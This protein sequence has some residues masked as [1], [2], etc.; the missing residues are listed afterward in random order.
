ME[1]RQQVQIKLRTLL[2]SYYK[3]EKDKTNSELKTI[4]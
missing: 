2:F 3:T 4:L 1:E